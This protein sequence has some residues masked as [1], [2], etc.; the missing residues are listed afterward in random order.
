MMQQQ[1]RFFESLT[2]LDVVE[3]VSIILL[4]SQA[5]L[6]ERLIT[7][8]PI[9][10]YFED[11]T[12]GADCFEAC[13]FFAEKFAKS[14]QRVVGNLR[15][16][17]TFAIEES[18]F[19]GPLIRLWDKGM[20]PRISTHMAKSHVIQRIGMD[21]EE[22]FPMIRSEAEPRWPITIRPTPTL[23]KYQSPE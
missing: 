4:L 17:A 13:Q 7:V 22:C 12:G 21:Y 1:I 14:D 20:E 15:I 16:Y 3:H 23:L 10:E 8:G 19:Q 5:E 9:S 2:R 6:L 18:C 11:Y